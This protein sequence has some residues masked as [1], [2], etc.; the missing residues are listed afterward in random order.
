MNSSSFTKFT[1]RLGVSLSLTPKAS[2][3]SVEPEMV[4][5]GDTPQELASKVVQLLRDPEC[6]QRVGAESRKRV[7]NEY[8]WRKSL[9]RLLALLENPACPA[10]APVES[11]TA[12]A[13]RAM[14]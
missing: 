4:E 10:P 5:F 6:R 3:H 7:G 14:G 12:P 1:A 13:V 2:E 9:D 8:N 11:R